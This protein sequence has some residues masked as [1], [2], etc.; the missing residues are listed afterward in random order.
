[1]DVDRGSIGDNDGSIGDNDDEA[2]DPRR[3][4]T[5]QPGG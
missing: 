3:Q 5:P 4:E 2:T 1:M